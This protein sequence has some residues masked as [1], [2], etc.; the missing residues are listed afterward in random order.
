MPSGS[1]CSY[2][3]P[4]GAPA[5][6]ARGS[7]AAAG[8]S[9]STA[10]WRWRASARHAAVAACAS[11]GSTTRRSPETPSASWGTSRAPARSRPAR[12]GSATP[13]TASA[14]LVRDQPVPG[15]LAARLV[16]GDV[17]RREDHVG[18]HELLFA[19]LVA[20]A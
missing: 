18:L 1:A 5:S 16:E 12:R 11:P 2:V 14:D 9:A 7:F 3:R 13:A 20:V 10:R 17:A 19:Y 6:A 8:S 4:R 15:E